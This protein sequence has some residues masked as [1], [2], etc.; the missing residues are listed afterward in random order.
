MSGGGDFIFLNLI[1]LNLLPYILLPTSTISDALRHN[2]ERIILLRQQNDQN[3][4]S[5]QNQMNISL[6]IRNVPLNYTNETGPSYFGNATN[7]GWRYLDHRMET[8]VRLQYADGENISTS[9]SFVK[10]YGWA[11]GH[12]S[13]LDDCSIVVANLGLH[14]DAS[15]GLLSNP[16]P[17]MTRSFWA[18]IYAAIIFL[19]DFASSSNRIAIWRS[20]LPQHFN[21][22]DGHFDHYQKTAK[23]C[24]AQNNA[25]IQEY[26]KVYNAGFAELCN[27]TKPSLCNSYEQTCTVNPMDMESPTV[28]KYYIDNQCCEKRLER[29]R[30]GGTNVSGTIYRW[31]IND[32]FDVPF[33]H[34]HDYDCSHFCYV[35]AL[36]EAAFERL[37][38]LIPSL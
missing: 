30:K 22:K 15:T 12:T 38:L 14:Y 35:P 34:A 33:W 3:H 7:H 8:A 31:E 36:Y 5:Q 1:I 25:S 10:N 11:P 19:V 4:T 13:F 26:N 28:Y 18:G 17:M 16:S 9:F 6:E 29:I 23:T 32:L 20:A 21:T 24:T 27:A 2:L 37:G